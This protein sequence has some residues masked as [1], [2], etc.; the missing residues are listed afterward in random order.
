MNFEEYLSE[1]KTSKVDAEKILAGNTWKLERKGILTA[2]GF[3]I[4]LVK[5]VIYKNNGRL[6]DPKKT[7]YVVGLTIRNK[8]GLPV[9]T[10]EKKVKGESQES[11]KKHKGNIDTLITWFNK[12]SNIKISFSDFS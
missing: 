11:D 9:Y 6:R 3:R 2:D 4:D 8:Q 12:H 10:D 7:T 1:S 5:D